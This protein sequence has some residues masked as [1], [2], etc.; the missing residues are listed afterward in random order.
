MVITVDYRLAPEYPYPIAVNDAVES[1]RWVRSTGKDRF[2]LDLERIAIGGTSAGANLAVVLCLKAAQEL[3]IR[4]CFQLLIV[5]VIDNTAT[6]EGI[7]R[8]NRNAP[9]L[10]P[11][12]MIWYRRMYIP[13]E[14]DWKNW[15]ASPHLAPEGLLK[16]L[17]PTWMAISGQDL[18]A[19][20]ARLF[21]RQLSELK[22]PV[23]VYEVEGGTHSILALCGILRKGEVMMKKAATALK[24][25]FSREICMKD[26]GANELV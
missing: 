16:R 13:I 18:L 23:T 6:V 8:Q 12:R 14:S 15:D 7:W 5:P 10:T 3:Q 4:I 17:P 24:T 11:S 1:L 20:E 26:L 22:V 19:P 9:W 21:A 2:N 25:E